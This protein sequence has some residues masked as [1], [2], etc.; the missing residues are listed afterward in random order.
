MELGFFPKPTKT[1]GFVLEI[2]DC[3]ASV[4]NNHVEG[5]DDLV[6]NNADNVIGCAKDQYKV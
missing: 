6:F 1:R 3:I 5:L 4:T 2:V